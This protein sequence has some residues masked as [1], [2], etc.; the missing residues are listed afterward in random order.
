VDL[1]EYQARD[2]FE[3]YEVPVLAGIVADT[4]EEVR[5][6]AEK[7]GGVVVV[8]AQVKTGGRG[9]A[10]GV[11][12]AKTPDEAYEAAKA[13]LG[14]DIKGHVVKRVMVAQGARIDK[15]Y[16]FSVLLDR[17]NRSYLS[18]CSVEGGMEIEELAVERPEALARIAVDPQ[19]GIDK[20]KAVEIAEAAGFSADL[21]DKVSDVFV[22][23]YQVYKREDATLVEV[24]PLVLTEEGEIIA[25]DGKVSLDENADFRHAGHALLEDKDAAA[26]PLE[27][28][29]KAND[30]NYVK[31]DGE[32]GVIGN[33]AGLVMSTLDVVAYA[34][35]SHG[36]VKPANFLDI[37]GGA[38]AEVMAAGLDVILGDP[39]VKSV[40]VNVFGGITACDAVAK[41]IVGALA[42]L[43]SSASKP[44]VVRLDG[45][46]VEEG[47][48]ILRDA[49]HPLVTLAET[50]D[51]GAD[52]AA[53]LANA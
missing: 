39:Q 2:L 50:M 49:N 4:P 18:L 29:A 42:E 12:V 8:K 5:A 52:K 34:G 19:Q 6:A 16:Y 23:L 44:L 45:N 40:F 17:A 51:E 30:L 47:R 10:G 32:V 15:E 1:Y 7:I 11:K 48:A 20:Q 24:N 28:K 37:G 36:G 13:I 35:E 14:L 43:G 25:L 41:G 31:L 46:K 38:S 26:D 9:K 22:K 53:E 3:K 21:V 33:G 27:A